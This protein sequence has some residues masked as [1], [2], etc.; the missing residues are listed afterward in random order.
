MAMDAEEA[1]KAIFRAVDEG[2]V[3]E[4]TRLLDA[5]PDLVRAED[6]PRGVYKPLLAASKY[7]HVDVVRL[8]LA[9]G[10]DVND[11]EYYGL[12]ALHAA[13]QQGNED[14]IDVLLRSGADSCWPDEEGVTSLIMASEEG[15]L[16]VVRQLLE[17]MGGRGLD[18]RTTHG[19]T[20]LYYACDRGRAEVVRELL[21]AGA[22]YTIADLA[23]QTPR[24]RAARKR[25]FRTAGVIRVSEKGVSFASLQSGG[26]HVVFQASIFQGM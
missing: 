25:R 3:D 4:V 16:G 2:N 5:R 11:R 7:G 1:R 18:H 21:L 20:A 24:Q 6:H 22:D 13:A 12:T 15:H 14:I 9:R 10:S 17:H 19:A 26:R 23:G 8:L